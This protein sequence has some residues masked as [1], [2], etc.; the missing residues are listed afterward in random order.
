METY[1]ILNIIG[2]IIVWWCG[3]Q[4]GR[5]L[6]EKKFKDFVVDGVIDELT[7]QIKEKEKND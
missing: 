2:Y 6:A 1:I 7:K 3:L 4:I 5:I